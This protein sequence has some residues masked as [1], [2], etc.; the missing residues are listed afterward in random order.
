MSIMDE[1]I[2]IL[3]KTDDGDS[4]TPLD[5]TLVQNAV[6]GYLS[7]AGEVAFADLY[8]QVADGTYAE[9]TRWFHQIEHLTRDHQGYVYWKGKRVEHFSYSD[10]DREAE[11]A[12]RLAAKCL[13]LEA[14]GLGVNGRTATNPDCYTAPVDTP[15]KIGLTRY[16]SFFKKDQQA[17]AIFYPANPKPGESG[18]VGAYK[19]KDGIHLL[20]YEGAYEGFHA[21][22]AAGWESAGVSQSYAETA[23]LLSATGLT[24]EEIAGLLVSA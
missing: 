6:N 14:N 11:G 10:A 23:D 21:A 19:D 18:V 17:M 22:L 3:E 16:Y 8:R 20:P 13:A 12:A 2:E 9:N 4:L 7:E 1:A 24:D 15:W 5:L